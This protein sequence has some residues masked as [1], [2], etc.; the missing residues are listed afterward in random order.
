MP[1]ASGNVRVQGNTP[2]HMHLNANEKQDIL[3]GTG[4]IWL[5]DKEV[6]RTSKK[7]VALIANTSTK[8]R[9]CD[10]NVQ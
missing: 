7:L 1:T 5:G 3:E 2:K 6:L 9:D 8:R 4:T 10:P